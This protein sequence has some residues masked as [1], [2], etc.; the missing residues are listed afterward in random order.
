[1]TIPAFPHSAATGNQEPAQPKPVM[2]TSGPAAPPGASKH[3]TIQFLHRV[4][5]VRR[6]RTMEGV[7]LLDEVEEMRLARREDGVRLLDHVEG[8]RRR[9]Q[10]EGVRLLRELTP[11]VRAARTLERELDRRLARRFNAFRY[12]RRDELG[13]SRLIADLLDPTAEHGQGATFLEAMLDLLEVI[14]GEPDPDRSRQRHRTTPRRRLFGRPGST[15]ANEIR[16]VRER[17]LP[18]RRRIDI[19][20]HIPTDNGPYCLAFENK[21]EADDS[22]GQCRDYLEF[23]DG[24]YRGRFLLVYLPPRY[25]M[26]DESSLSVADRERWKDHF[27]VLP[28]CPDDRARPGDDDSSDPDGAAPM[29]ADSA[30]GDALAEDDATAARDG[31]AVGDSA[32]LADWFGRCCTLAG[33][34]RLRWFLREAQLFCQHHFRDSPMTDTEARFLRVYLDENPKHLHAAFAVY[35]AWPAAVHNVCQRFLEHLKDRIAERVRNEFPEIADELAVE[36]RYGRDKPYESYLCVYR[37]GWMQYEGGSRK[38]DRRTSVMLQNRKRGPERWRWGV[39]SG[40]PKR[41]MTELEKQRRAGV[42]RSL[43]QHGLSTSSDPGHWPHFNRPRYRNWSVIV[44]ELGLELADRGGKITEYYVNGFLRIAE[45]AIPAINE[46]EM[47]KSSASDSE[48]S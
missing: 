40:R 30:P 36:C 5:R 7:R 14:P 18:G 26:P 39:R 24:E 48:D 28:Y 20:V 8:I 42:E 38:S 4:T 32:S 29:P 22:P 2:Q 19:T 33:P 10:R 34:E 3:T 45:K 41:D 12:L 1:M 9:R 16:V 11:H 15:G 44:P 23:L 21:P 6:A 37:D 47:D 27:R 46:V 17:G 31:A 43:K 13:L 25:R 35:R